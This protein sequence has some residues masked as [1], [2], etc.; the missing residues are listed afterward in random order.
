MPHIAGYL[1]TQLVLP[2]MNVMMTTRL[3]RA[4]LAILGTRILGSG[5]SPQTP[6]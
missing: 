2:A 1:L 4:I 5:A 6:E 3:I